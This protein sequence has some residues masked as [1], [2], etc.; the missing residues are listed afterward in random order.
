MEKFKITNLIKR[1]VAKKVKAEMQR[2]FKNGEYSE[3]GVMYDPS[4]ENYSLGNFYLAES[5]NIEKEEY[6]GKMLFKLFEHYKADGK[7]T[8]KEI[9]NIIFG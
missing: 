4:Q 9:E 2:Q 1:E 7:L 5:S 3:V 6:E 8:L